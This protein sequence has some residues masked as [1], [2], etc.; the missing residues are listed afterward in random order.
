MSTMTQ[1]S[2]PATDRASSA[3]TEPGRRGFGLRGMTWLIWRQHRAAYWILL[4]GAA[5][6]VAAFLYYRDQAMPFLESRG[7]PGELKEGWAA[8]Y[9]WDPLST[10]SRALEF[11][12]PVIGIFLG[13]PLLA[14]DLETNTAKLV[15]SQSASPVRWLATKL[16]LT[17]LV[18]VVATTA[19]SV[20]YTSWWSPT[21][22]VHHT[23]NFTWA[24]ALTYTG[25]IPTALALLT[26]M[27][28]VAIGMLLRRTLAAMFVTLGF[29]LV[30]RLAWEKIRLL[31]GE[32]VT[33]TAP[34]G[35]GKDSPLVPEG[36][37]QVDAFY[38]TSSGGQRPTDTCLD[39]IGLEKQQAC[40]DKAGI[41]EWVVKYIP[42]SEMSSMQWL[43]A[44]AMF[45][46]SA[47]IAAFI[48]LWGRK[49][50]V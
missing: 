45:A 11:L 16:G 46:A 1:T 15:N 31:P 39:V 47:G 42:L 40:M 8:K 17:T 50:L 9:D 4:V 5:L 29:A 30:V 35:A 48:I 23:Y 38:A 25:P 24:D 7:W 2:N 21:K 6:T 43:C 28:G 13:A 37:H 3:G 10:Y 34:A 22:T 33:M 12:P 44:S 18:V 14:G 49:R 36:G 32:V 20:A 26:M 27:G 41:K 19:I